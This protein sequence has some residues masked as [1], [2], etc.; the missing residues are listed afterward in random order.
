MND[1]SARALRKIHALDAVL[2]ALMHAVYTDVARHAL[3]L[4]G[5]ACADGRSRR[6]CLGP[7][8]PLVLVRLASAQ[9]VQVG[10][11]DAR[12]ALVARVAEHQ[13]SAEWKL[14]ERSAYG[15]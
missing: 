8:P 5:A 12:Q 10:N 11:R 2:I 14:R 9:V 4:R 3:R 6:V 7:V 1:A 13:I 15:G